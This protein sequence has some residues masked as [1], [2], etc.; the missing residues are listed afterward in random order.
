M[1]VE[2]VVHIILRKLPS[3]HA[4][5]F[6]GLAIEGGMVGREEYVTD[7]GCGRIVG[8]HITIQLGV[9]HLLVLFLNRSYTEIDKTMIEAK[10]SILPCTIAQLFKSYFIDML[11]EWNG[12]TAFKNSTST[13]FIMVKYSCNPSDNDFIL[14]DNFYVSKATCERIGRRA[15]PVLFVVA[16]TF[17]LFQF[18][19][20][21][22]VVSTTADI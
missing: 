7:I 16:E 10:K 17:T 9:N 12:R 6:C 22:V 19:S 14:L 8:L 13:T 1:R 11:M 21:M 20:G 18:L 3:I 4:E 2:P 15:S 5:S